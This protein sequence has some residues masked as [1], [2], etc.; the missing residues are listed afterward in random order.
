MPLKER[1]CRI[2]RSSRKRE[3][4]LYLDEGALLEDLPEGLR[5]DLGTLTE[6][7]TLAIGPQRRL[8]RAQA[9]QVLEAIEKQGYFLQLPPSMDPGV[10]THGG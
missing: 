8:A 1:N 3:L 7:M 9:R 10:F 5:R 6:I 2:Y 4:Y